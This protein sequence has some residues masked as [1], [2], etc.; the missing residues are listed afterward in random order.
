MGGRIGGL[1]V[2]GGRNEDT[3]K[4]YLSLQP[5]RAM[6][7]REV[8]MTPR[9]SFREKERAPAVAGEGAC[10][11]QK[12]LQIALTTHLTTLQ[13][14]TEAQTMVGQWWAGPHPE[15]DCLDV[16]VLGPVGYYKL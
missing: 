10:L 6:T 5:V 2:T 8:G 3:L 13:S 7:L 9:I 12:K 11:L 14:E 16:N 1:F 4:R 15:W